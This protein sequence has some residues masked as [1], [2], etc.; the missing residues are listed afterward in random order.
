MR[1]FKDALGR[2]WMLQLTVASSMK[3]RQATDVVLQRMFD[4]GLKP[5]AELAGDYEKVYHVLWEMCEKQAASMPFVDPITKEEKASTGP[6]EFAE[7]L[8]GDGL[9][10]GWEALVRTTADF[11]T[12]QEAREAAHAILDKINQGTKSLGRGAMEFVQQL[13]GNQMGIDIL[14]FATSGRASQVSNQTT[15]QPAS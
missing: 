12:S 8:A 9:A 4:D 2:N 5:M 11:F 13:D 14:N 7:G 3:V 10:N 15:E 1:S 6:I